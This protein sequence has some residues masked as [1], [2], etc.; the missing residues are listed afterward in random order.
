MKYGPKK[1]MKWWIEI[2]GKKENYKIH[3]TVVAWLWD[4]TEDVQSTTWHQ[5][6][7]YAIDDQDLELPRSQRKIILND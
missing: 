4:D 6:I 3:F 5:G 1:Q 2:M 7:N